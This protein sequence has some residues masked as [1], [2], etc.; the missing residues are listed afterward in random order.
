MSDSDKADFE[1]FESEAEDL[2]EEFRSRSKA[3]IAH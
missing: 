2:I 3:L 1:A